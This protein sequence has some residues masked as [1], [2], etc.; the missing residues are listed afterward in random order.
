MKWV[1]GTN[2]SSAKQKKKHC[3]PVMIL[4]VSFA[5]ALSVQWG[6]KD[7]YEIVRK[8]DQTVQPKAQ[9]HRKPLQPGPPGDWFCTLG[10]GTAEL[11]AEARSGLHGPEERHTCKVAVQH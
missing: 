8:V 7:N 5:Q 10:T 9:D 6:D 4:A 1:C 11:V 3:M 2:K